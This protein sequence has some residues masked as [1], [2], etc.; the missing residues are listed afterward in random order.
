MIFLLPFLPAF[1][2]AT[3]SIGEA[4]GIGA[5]LIGIGAAIKGT[6]D[7][8]EAKTIQ[9]NAVIAYQQTLR[10]IDRKA[11]EVRKKLEAFG[12]LKLRTYTGI[13]RDAV[14]AL[15]R[16]ITVDL[17]PFRDVQVENIRFLHDELRG[18]GE[19][20]IKASDVLSCLSAGITTAANDRFLYKDTP[21]VFQTIGAF[22]LKK[23]PAAALP[24]IPYAAITVAGITWGIS[25][26]AAKL[27]AETNAVYASSE[28]EK[29]K[30]VE[31]GFDALLALI[32][33][34]ENLI[35]TLTGKLRLALAELKGEAET[36]EVPGR[37]ENALSLTRTLKQVIEVDL[38]TGNGLLSPESGV[39]FYA[40]K[41]EYAH[42]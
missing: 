10:R 23:A 31:T 32:A 1:A 42:G 12:L 34:G 7:Y 28:I 33:E 21:P 29:L 25:G 2:A 22:G 3:L 14:E 27:Q 39:L 35:K 5:S 38:C 40:V 19:S 20:V 4:I 37:I 41:K 8:H 24:P 26:S 9:E 36:E 15:S 18:L 13:I 30:A 6:A 17:S 16:F 11:G